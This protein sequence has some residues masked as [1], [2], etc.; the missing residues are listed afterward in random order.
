MVN[1]IEKS[2]LSKVQYKKVFSI[3]IVH[4]L[5][6]SERGKYQYFQSFSLNPHIELSPDVL[7]RLKHDR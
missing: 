6:S 4:Y 2:N 7:T 3:A 5:F 1:Q